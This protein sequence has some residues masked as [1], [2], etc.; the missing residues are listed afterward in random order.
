MGSCSTY[1]SSSKEEIVFVHIELSCSF[2]YFRTH[3]EREQQLVAF[4]QTTACKPEQALKKFKLIRKR[5][6]TTEYTQLNP[7]DEKRL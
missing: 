5:T 2:Q 7:S 6:V 4:K 3:L 1:H